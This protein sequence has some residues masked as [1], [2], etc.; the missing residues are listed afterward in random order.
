MEVGWETSAPPPALDPEAN[1]IEAWRANL[2]DGTETASDEHATF[3][4][5]AHQ[6]SS[7][8]VRV[9]GRGEFT[10]A[11]VHEHGDRLRMFTRRA[12][13]M[14]GR[15]TGGVAVNMPVLELRRVGGHFVR[16]YIHPDHGPIFS[17]LDI[18]L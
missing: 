17:T 9:Q 6:V 4:A 8:T 3:D 1:A 16:L 5:V 14:G 11:G 7:V 2:A 10:L 12:I 18:N 13:R 15:S